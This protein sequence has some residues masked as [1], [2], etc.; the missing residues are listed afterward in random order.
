LDLVRSILILWTFT[1]LVVHGHLIVAFSVGFASVVAI[2]VSVHTKADVWC[3][4]FPHLVLY[5]GVCGRGWW[6][7]HLTPPFIKNKDTADID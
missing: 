6:L 4:I 7:L 2:C 3:S 5:G 1:R